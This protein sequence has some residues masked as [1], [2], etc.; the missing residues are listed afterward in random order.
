MARD[1][2]G[3]YSIIREVGRGGM[4]AVYEA[5]SGQGDRVAI[6]TMIT[7]PDLDSRARWEM[8][9]RFMTEARAIRALEH[10]NVVSVLDTGEDQGEFYI[11]MEFLDGQSVRQLLDMMGPISLQ[12]AVNI[13]CD[14]CAALKYAHEHGV[15]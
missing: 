13:I 11:V 2:L 1:K 9:D 5:K 3:D 10:K 7:P 8:V 6:K 14:V 15:I 4:G 12:R